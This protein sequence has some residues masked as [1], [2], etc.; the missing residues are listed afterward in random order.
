MADKVIEVV[1][2]VPGFL[3]G[4]V[5]FGAEDNTGIGF[6]CALGVANL[7]FDTGIFPLTAVVLVLIGAVCAQ[8]KGANKLNITTKTLIRTK[9]RM[10]L[11]SITGGYQD[12]T[13]TT[14]GGRADY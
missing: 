10:A 7:F 13:V 9:K 14:G 5:C 11:S 6:S 8:L 3:A 4:A 12:T 1:V 2:S